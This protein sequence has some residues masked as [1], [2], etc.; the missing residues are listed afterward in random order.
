M[1]F[2]LRAYEPADFESLYALDQACY[3][4]GIAYSRSTL[5]WFLG[6]P[7]RECLVAVASTS[8]GAAS[9]GTIIGFILADV[10]VSEAHIITLDVSESHRRLGIGTALLREM[11]KRLGERGVSRVS[12]ETKTSSEAAVAFWQ[13]HDYRATGV[14]RRYYLNRFDA[15]AMSKRLPG[16]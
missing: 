5:R 7:G 11:E 3:V 15:L 2:T 14:L 10:E 6:L 12:L 16:K 4:R 1:S 8:P 9:Q 13:A